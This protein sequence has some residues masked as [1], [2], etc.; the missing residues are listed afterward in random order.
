MSYRVTFDKHLGFVLEIRESD[1]DGK[2]AIV[3]E[4]QDQLQALFEEFQIAYQNAVEPG[5]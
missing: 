5:W 2:N 1:L 3:L 4:D